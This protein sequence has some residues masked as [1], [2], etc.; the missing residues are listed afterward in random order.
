ME[1]S[2]KIREVLSTLVWWKLG[3]PY[4]KF[5]SKPHSPKKCRL[6]L[7]SLIIKIKR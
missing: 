7:N 5:N 1:M 6:F 4:L 2:N 3:G